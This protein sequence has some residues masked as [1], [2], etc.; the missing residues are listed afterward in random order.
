MSAGHSY[1]VTSDERYDVVDQEP[2]HV[3]AVNERVFVF[4]QLSRI[5][6]IDSPTIDL[7]E[8]LHA[9][10]GILDVFVD[11]VNP[12]AKTFSVCVGKKEPQ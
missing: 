4:R 10:C 6:E 11:E 2:L 5:G 12:Y 3:R 7:R 9:R 1:I 8:S